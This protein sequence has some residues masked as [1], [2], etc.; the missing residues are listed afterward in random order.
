MSMELMEKVLNET[1]SKV[2]DVLSEANVLANDLPQFDPEFFPEIPYSYQKILQLIET[3]ENEYG[4]Y[5]S[6][7]RFSEVSLHVLNDY[8]ESQ[9]SMFK[10]FEFRDG[11]YLAFNQIME[12]DEARTLAFIP[13]T[14]H[15]KNQKGI[16]YQG[17]WKNSKNVGGD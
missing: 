1:Q 3:I 11:A 12:L 6:Y 17:T 9:K 14:V 10:S 16:T 13:K 4:Y 8:K 2:A 5:L 7:D 15:T